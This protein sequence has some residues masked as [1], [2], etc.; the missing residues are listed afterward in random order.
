MI[1]GLTGGIGSGKTLASEY[2]RIHYGFDIL[3][4]D[5]TARDIV[6]RGSPL[7]DRITA[8]FGV[9]SLMPDGTLN[10]GYL[11]EQIFSNPAEKDWLESVTHPE[12]RH[13]TLERI[14]ATA[15][16][17][18]LILVSPL[19]FESHQDSLCD[20]TV[21]ITVP[22]DI[23][24]ARVKRRDNNTAVQIKRIMQNQLSDDNRTER[25]DHIV[26]NDGTKEHLYQQLDHL[27]FSWK[28]S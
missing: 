18:V 17:K 5:V 15:Q 25:A 9:N 19:L 4:N 27:A 10:R 26:Y 13:L 1:I 7:L 6:V 11:R 8:H 23:Q 22:L 3:D 24:I 28:K 21:V 2:F 16:H 14:A 20:Q 12:I